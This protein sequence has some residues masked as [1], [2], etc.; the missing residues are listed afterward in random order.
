MYSAVNVLNAAE[1][2]TLKWLVFM[3]FTS[4][5]KKR[6]RETNKDFPRPSIPKGICCHQMYV[7]E[8]E[9]WLQI[10][11]DDGTRPAPE[12]SLPLCQLYQLRALVPLDEWLHLSEPGFHHLSN[13]NS[14]D[15]CLTETCNY[16]QVLGKQ[17]W[18]VSRSIAF[19]QGPL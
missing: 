5:E 10:L 18:S 14:N 1:L 9:V 8:C 7:I 19:H 11:R 3:G 16:L 2:F 12:P 6:E 17:N 4:T 15:L 13:G